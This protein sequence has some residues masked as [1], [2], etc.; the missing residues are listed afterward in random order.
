[1]MQILKYMLCTNH[2]NL[3]KPSPNILFGLTLLSISIFFMAGPLIAIE[4]RD[5]DGNVY[6]TLLNGDNDTLT[7][8]DGLFHSALSAGNG[9]DKGAYTT[10]A[11]GD[12]IW[13]EATTVSPDEGELIWTGVVVGD[14]INGSYLHTRKGWFLFGDTTKKKHFE[15]SLKAE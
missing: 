5:L 7:F 14:A 9:H 2:A 8:R 12:K 10:V 15:G 4:P 6:A 11:Q 13:F 1:M 3:T